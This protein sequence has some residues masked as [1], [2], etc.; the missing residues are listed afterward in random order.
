MILKKGVRVRVLNGQSDRFNQTGVITKMTGTTAWVKFGFFSK[1]EKF[2][3]RE[4]T[5]AA[6]KEKWGILK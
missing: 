3:A 1:A 4:L 2:R 6:G 5:V